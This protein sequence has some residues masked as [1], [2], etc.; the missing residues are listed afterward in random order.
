MRAVLFEVE[1]R[2]QRLWCGKDLM[3][4]RSTPFRGRAIG[5]LKEEGW[6]QGTGKKGQ[7][8]CPVWMELLVLSPLALAGGGAADS[9]AASC[10]LIV[11]VLVPLLLVR[12]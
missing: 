3:S 1:S 12:L 11:V 5:M 9:P 8:K 2:E 6:R 4:C 7:V 10:V